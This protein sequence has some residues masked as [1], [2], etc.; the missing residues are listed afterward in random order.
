METPLILPGVNHCTGLVQMEYRSTLDGRDGSS[1]EHGQRN[2]G[3]RREPPACNLVLHRT[4]ERFS[5]LENLT[6][7]PRTDQFRNRILVKERAALVCNLVRP[8]RAQAGAV[9]GE[10]G[11][12]V[13]RLPPPPAEESSFPGSRIFVGAPPRHRPAP[14]APVAEPSQRRAHLRQWRPV[15]GGEQP[16]QQAGIRQPALLAIQRPGRHIL[17]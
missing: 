16:N 15:P 13:R 14:P 7:G 11:L 17:Q 6:L 2:T 8:C 1:G 9:L 3:V 5:A 10:I 12:S 4:A